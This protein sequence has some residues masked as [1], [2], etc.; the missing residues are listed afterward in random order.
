MEILEL[1]AL[2]TPAEEN[3]S[4]SSLSVV[5]CGISTVSTILC[6]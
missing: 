6:L 4:V 1:Q 5:N 2:E 3:D